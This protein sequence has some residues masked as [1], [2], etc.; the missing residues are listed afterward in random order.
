M[1]VSSQLA[2]T[3]VVMVSKQHKHTTPSRS[4]GEGPTCRHHNIKQAPSEGICK[5]AC[6]RLEQSESVKKKKK[7]PTQTRHLN[8]RLEA[9]HITTQ[10]PTFVADKKL[11]C[12]KNRFIL[13]FVAL[14]FSC[15]ATRKCRH[16]SPAHT[17]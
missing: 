2:L 1:S 15:L 3:V 10:H 6:G 17:K 13:C 5:A 7:K 14:L 9:Q 4:G 8:I 12:V 11:F 16:I